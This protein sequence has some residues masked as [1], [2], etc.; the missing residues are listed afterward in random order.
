MARYAASFRFRLL[1]RQL[2]WAWAASDITVGTVLLAL[3]W[4][5]DE[6][7]AYGLGWSVP[8][9]WAAIGA[10]STTVWAQRSLRIEK[11]K[12]KGK[13]EIDPERMM[14]KPPVFNAAARSW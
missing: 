4:T 5:V 1:L 14:W 6:E 2:Q 7:V 13:R 10:C 12:G 3:I 9:I 11:E 8:T